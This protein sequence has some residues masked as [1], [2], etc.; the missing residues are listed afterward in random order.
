MAASRA[1]TSTLF[2]SFDRVVDRPDPLHQ[3]RTA[4]QQREFLK[5]RVKEDVPLEELV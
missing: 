2:A 4:N 3:H 5:G 1:L